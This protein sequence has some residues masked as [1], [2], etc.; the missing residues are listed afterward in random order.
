MISGIR[1]TGNSCFMNSALQ[2]I[3]PIFQEYF[4]SKSFLENCSNQTQLQFL[5]LYRNFIENIQ[6]NNIHQVHRYLIPIRKYLSTT[7]ECKRFINRQPADSYEF[8]IQFVDLLSTYL[9]Y[10]V[11]VNIKTNIPENMLD[12]KDKQRLRLYQKIQKN[13]RKMSIVDEKLQGYTR[14]TISCGFEDCH[15]FSEIFESFYTLSL[16]ISSSTT[17][18]ES[19]EEFV[20]PTKLDEKNMWYCDRCK[21]KSQAIKKTSIWNT[22]EYVVICYKRYQYTPRGFVKNQKN[23]QTP[24]SLNMEKYTEDNSQN[25]YQVIGMNIHKGHFHNGHYIS[26]R[27]VGN[28]WIV[29]NDSQT[30]TISQNKIPIHSSYYVLYKRI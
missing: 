23:I 6:K 14:T 4:L 11:D 12:E 13:Q 22:C 8:F 15:N 16:P 27:K 25:N 17:L 28:Q 1:N 18:Y 29:C 2:L 10:E 20:K 5:E 3:N 30:H 19:L 21:R 9:T 7:D 24:F 26:I